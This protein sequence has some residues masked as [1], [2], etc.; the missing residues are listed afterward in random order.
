[1]P[2]SLPVRLVALGAL[3]A[4]ASCSSN[5]APQLLPIDAQTAYVGSRFELKVAAFDP[6]EER[7]IYSF[8]CPTLKL[9][10]RARIIRLSDNEALFSWTP[11]GSDVGQHQLDII[12]SDGDEW[13]VEAVSLTVKPGTDPDTAPVFRRPLG[14][15]T[16][17]D[18]KTEQCLKLEVEVEDPDSTNVELRQENQIKGS[19]FKATGSLRALFSWCP[20]AAQAAKQRHMLKLVAD[21][22][23]NPPVTKNYTVLLRSSLPVNCPGA[24]PVVLHTAVKPQT[25]L[26][27][28]RVSAGITDDKGIKG[29]PTLYYS[30]TKPQSLAYLDYSKLSQVSMYKLPDK[31]TTYSG[32][33]PNPIKALPVGS[34]RTVYYVI[35]AEDDDDKQGNCDHRTQAPSGSMYSVRITRPATKS[36]SKTS[37]CPVGQVCH[38]SSKACIP[39]A[40]TPKDSNG[41]KLLWEQA[42]CPSGHFCPRPGPASA[43]PGHCAVSCT[44]D[45]DC[46]T[47][48]VCKVFD[49][50]QGCGKPGQG[51]VGQ[52]CTDATNCKGKAMCLPWTG[53]YCAISDCDTYGYYSGACPK[54][55]ACIPRVDSRFSAGKHWLCMQL[56]KDNTDCRTGHGYSCTSLKDDQDSARTVCS[57]PGK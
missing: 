13:D 57:K 27:D 36:C 32:Y 19:T 11:L 21:D 5:S 49:T 42:D 2:W 31:F 15:G 17:L 28:I 16:T 20:A 51:L 46:Q 3:V 26:G 8:S 38:G 12:A 30:T 25:T 34:A 10:D 48:A 18:L 35:V 22:H 50:K 39:D 43:T 33:L 54:G 6:D 1:M 40:C 41:D 53:G 24:A 47:G 45:K 37:G 23:D 52:P 56:C 4:L 14:E 44:K 55:A 9:K 29:T 7:L